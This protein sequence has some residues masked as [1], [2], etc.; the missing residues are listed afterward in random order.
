MSK[1]DYYE[2]LGVSRSATSD[3]IKKAYRKLAMQYHPDR[4][5]GDAE[6]ENKFK[7]IS[8]AYSVL[9]DDQKRAHYDRFGHS[10]PGA[11]GGGFEFSFGSEG[12]DPFELFRSVFG[13]NFGG[14]G[15]D[16]FTQS[17]RA[18]SGSRRGSDLTVDLNLTLEEIAEGTT[19]KIKVKVYGKCETCNGTGSQ[20]GRMDVCSQCQGTGEMRQVSQSFFGRM[21]NIT[22]CS[23][24]GGVGRVVRNVC[25][26]CGGGGLKRIEK[27][28]SVKVP[29]GVASGQY[30]RLRGEGNRGR[31]GGTAGDIIVQFHE[32]EHKHFTRH[33]D[34]V[35]YEL[36]ISYPQAV[37]GGSVDVPTLGGIAR[38]TI[39]PGTQPGKLFR[40][41][42]K[43]I[44]HINGSGCGD[45]LVRV[46]I[47]VPKKVGP[48]ERKMLE[49]LESSGAVSPPLDGRS[50]FDRIKDAII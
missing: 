48:A 6:A 7:E 33:G 20:D 47:F 17:E 21:V 32:L 27:T 42:G 18:R 41:R 16:V 49:A 4:N 34:D 29:A 31:F 9:S 28:V 37:L 50:L 45:Q 39:P 3:E 44:T 8:E 10:A 43:G 5:Q 35:L 24:C 13:S 23:V 12:F 30:L 22:T 15:E 19:K 26:V 2:V 11:P 38:L 1:R 40:M 14:F 25:S 36:T 46:N